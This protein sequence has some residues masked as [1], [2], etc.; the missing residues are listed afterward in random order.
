MNLNQKLINFYNKNEIIP[1]RQTGADKT[2]FY[3]RGILYNTLGL[4]PTSF[5]NLK[6]IE[7]GPG[8][9]QNALYTSTLEP[10]NLTLLEPSKSGIN[11]IKKL[12]K[13]K[14][15]KCP[16]KLINKT[17]ENFYKKNHNQF[18]I[19]IC[20]GLLGSSGYKDPKILLKYLKHIVKKK[21]SLI[22][23]CE[24]EVGFLSEQLKRLV[25]K[26][27]LHEFRVKNNFEEKINFLKPYFNIHLESFKGGS[28]RKIND[29]IADVLISPALDTPFL[30]I[31]DAIKKLKNS[32]RT[33]GTSP[34]IT[35]ELIYYKVA[36]KISS[37]FEN[38]SVLKSYHVNIVNYIDYRIEPKHVSAKLSKKIFLQCKNICREVQNIKNINKKSFLNIIKKLNTLKTDLPND[39]SITKKSIGEAIK[40]LKNKKI[41]V[42][43][44][45][46][47]KNFAG[48]LGK[49]QTYMH[50]SKK[51]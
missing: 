19:V 16:T 36:S 13:K 32:F 45:K 43:T 22:I 51:S 46:K 10:K 5:K 18:D 30:R 24:D 23:T 38:D 44:F 11:E 48:W 35:G 17:I 12:I 15:F 8:S 14:K 41:K 42:K 4:P 26:K 31:S 47:F 39:F 2:R 50:F 25:T 40:I 1:V 3:G 21:G 20:E 9:G 34:R 49:C 7:I 27:I 37:D 6:V 33:I 28:K 29:W